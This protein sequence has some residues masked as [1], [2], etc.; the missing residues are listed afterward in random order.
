MCGARGDADWEM[1]ML[2]RFSAFNFTIVPAKVTGADIPEM[3]IEW[4]SIGTPALANSTCASTAPLSKDKG[5]I[6][7]VAQE[8]I[9][10]L[11]SSSG[12]PAMMDP[13]SIILFA[14]RALVQSP[15]T[16]RLQFW[17]AVQS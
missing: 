13:S 12:P 6:G 2:A 10:L 5:E 8:K 9:G 15:W 7:F 14:S 3:D 11:L 1:T 16:W 4:Q 17:N